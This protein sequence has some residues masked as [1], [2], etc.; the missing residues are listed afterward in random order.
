M[1]AWWLEG[2]DGRLFTSRGL[3]LSVRRRCFAKGARSAQGKRVVVLCYVRY[4]VGA[5]VQGSTTSSHL[6]ASAR[7]R[8]LGEE[9]ILSSG[10]NDAPFSKT[11]LRRILLKNRV[12]ALLL[13]PASYGGELTKGDVRLRSGCWSVAREDERIVA[14]GSSPA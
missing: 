4:T 1:Y 3:E 12:D 11:A 13:G 10:D 5:L 6:L 7:Y 9:I 14:R 8:Y 2:V